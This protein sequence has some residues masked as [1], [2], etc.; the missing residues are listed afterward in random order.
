M[1]K[2]IK[3]VLCWAAFFGMIGLAGYF[4]SLILLI[5]FTPVIAYIAINYNSWTS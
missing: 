4:N 3:A 2:F 1:D 5:I